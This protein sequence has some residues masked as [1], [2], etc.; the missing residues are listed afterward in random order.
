MAKLTL[1]EDF[2]VTISGKSLQD[3]MKAFGFTVGS[4]VQFDDNTIFDQFSANRIK[5]KT[6]PYSKSVLEAYYGK[7]DK[8]VAEEHSDFIDF[9]RGVALVIA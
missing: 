1:N 9:G 3:R 6:V 4:S 8:Q 2:S 5:T 7:Y